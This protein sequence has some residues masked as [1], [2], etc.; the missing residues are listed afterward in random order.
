[1]RERHERSWT[2]GTERAGSVGIAYSLAQTHA[3]AP[4]PVFPEFLLAAISGVEG[5]PQQRNIGSFQPFHP[6]RN[7]NML[8]ASRY[9]D[10]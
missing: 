3:Y 8:Q 1:L 5:K 7:R 6:Q 10:Q 9:K 4:F 2:E